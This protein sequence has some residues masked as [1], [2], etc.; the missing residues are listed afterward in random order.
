LIIRKIAR[1]IIGYAYD[2]KASDI[3]LIPQTDY[4]DYYVRIHGQR[5]LVARKDL[6]EML[7]LISFLKYSA[8]MNISEN[9]RP[10]S[11]TLDFELPTE[12]L[13]LRLSSIGNYKNE[14]SLVIRLLYQDTGQLNFYFPD[15][16]QLIAANLY[17]RGLFI[18]SGPTGSGKTT[19]LYQLAKQVAIEETVIAIEDPVEIRAPEILQLQ[20]N[21]AADMSY[22]QLISGVLRHRPDTLII[23]EIRDAQTAKAAVTAALSGHLVL[24]T[25]HARSSGGVVERL[26]DLNL[27]EVV[28][29]NTLTAICYQRLFTDCQQTPKVLCDI[30]MAQDLKACLQKPQQQFVDWQSNMKLLLQYQLIDQ[31]TYQTFKEG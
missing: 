26:L 21:E 6:K 8:Q 19:T 30:M 22:T 14:E 28:L 29:Q 23:G 7:G 27:S 2:L 4:Y 24:T 9:R 31:Q 16:L 15:Q 18:F 20:V 12:V 25:L 10:Q 13:Q 5:H 11:G 17:R 3:Y 1:D